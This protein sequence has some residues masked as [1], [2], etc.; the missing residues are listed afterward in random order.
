MS[1]AAGAVAVDHEAPPAI[2]IGAGPAG[3]M[4]A[5]VLAGAGVPV[6][7]FDAMA[8]AGRKLLL[9]GRGGLNLAHSEP[10]ER[11]LERYAAAS[12]PLAPLLRA[13]VGLHAAAAAAVV[14]TPELW[15]WRVG[16]LAANHALLTASGLWPRSDWLGPN[17]LRLPP[18]TGTA[19]QIAITIDDGP[20]PE[21]TPAVLDLLAE[22]HACATFFCSGEQVRRHPQLAREIQR[23]GHHLENHSQ[24]HLHRFSLL[25]PR[26]LRR[27]I[28]AAQA[29]IADTVGRAPRLFRAPA[30][31]R[32]PLLDPVLQTF[33]LRLASWTR[34]GFDTRASDAAPVLARLLRDLRGGDILL[35][36]DG[37]CGVTPTG[38]PLVLDVLPQ[39]LAAADALGLAT[40]R[41]A[42]ALNDTAAAP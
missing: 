20:H 2:V 25:G 13:S 37:H 19:A 18:S 1:A 10:L 21:V 30:G 8:S 35:L 27:E 4:A 12:A 29:T 38:R 26:G 32:S 15:P 31:L 39:L 3:L 34:R 16:T 28:G 36:H 6:H 5:E 22:R 11:Q 24:R 41:L 17:L 7:V 42:D 9:A 14:L 33:G 23:R 40:V